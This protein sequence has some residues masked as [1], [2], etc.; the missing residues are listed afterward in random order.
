V[1]TAGY[2]YEVEARLYR[3]GT[4]IMSQPLSATGASAGDQTEILSITYVDT[5]LSTTTST[6]EVRTIVTSATNVTS[7]SSFDRNINAIVFIP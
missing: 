4:L 5:A 6:Y 2:V 1:T 3:D 7:A